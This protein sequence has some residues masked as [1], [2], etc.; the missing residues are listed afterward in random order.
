MLSISE[1][2]G[3]K[4]LGLIAI[5]IR[6][7]TLFNRAL[8]LSNSFHGRHLS[9]SIFK[10]LA[11][12]LTSLSF[13]SQVTD[14]PGFTN[15]EFLQA[16]SW[17]R[18]AD[19]K[20][21]E[22]A[23][24]GDVVRFSKAWQASR[25]AIKGLVTCG[26]RAL[27]SQQAFP[28]EAGLARL[29]TQTIKQVSKKPAGRIHRPVNKPAVN[30]SSHVGQLANEVTDAVC[31]EELRPFAM[32]AS[33]ELLANAS[34]RLPIDQFFR[35]WR[36]TLSELL[37]WPTEIYDDPTTPADVILVEHGEIPFVGGLVFREIASASNL[38]KS[39][40]KILSSEMVDRTDSDGT[41][42]AEILPRFPLWVASLIRST[43]LMERFQVGQWNTDQSQLLGNIIDRAIHMCGP[44]GRSALTN[45]LELDMFPV[46]ATAVES[47]EL[48]LV[49]STIDYLQ[50]VQRSIEGKPQRRTRA[51]IST[52]PS[53][54]SDWAKFALLRSDLS[55]QADCVAITHHQ[56]L[57]QMDVTAL[58]QPLIH[59][60]W[61]LKLSLG[62]AEVELAE[63][64]SC[65]CW[66]SDPDA[67][68][69]ELQMTGPGKLRVER[70]VMLS[71]KDRFLVVADAITGVSSI[72]A[73]KT[74][75][76]KSQNGKSS[77]SG[78][79][80]IEYESRLSL[81]PGLTG[82]CEGTTREGRIAGRKLKSRVFP[83]AIPQD[84]VNS[85]PHELSFQGNELV[86]KQVAEGDGLFAPLVLVWHPERTRVD[87]QWRTLTVTEE[88]K[89]VAPDVAVG[90]RLKLGKFQLLISRSLKKTGNSRA[91]LGHHTFNETVIATF[92]ENGDV[93]PIL[94]VE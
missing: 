66:Q 62:D 9:R 24:Q 32:L 54:Q 91:C 58:G 26:E 55:V 35:L 18:S 84:R 65:V 13:S 28:E 20:I 53:N 45:G 77:P 74:E 23:A 90:Y 30:W 73:G 71:R 36:H 79:P 3:N 89:V 93:D 1:V 31:S 72:D 56:P 11:M 69:I 85:T 4:H 25:A 10:R 43:L 86:L 48:G 52:M 67:D 80:R 82:S 42:H 92:D 70:L 57:P 51:A 7:V 41:P 59:G 83:L 75:T 14:L 60:D 46:L 47:L 76:Q 22:A 34:H 33:L 5:E 44:S 2:S 12:S 38:V 6:S 64:W 19:S 15:S 94:M 29:I 68:Y 61:K 17:D 49:G 39:G 8:K 16:L 50:A 21:R 87:A 37:M 78:K 40:R 81:S 27:W 63:E 88:G